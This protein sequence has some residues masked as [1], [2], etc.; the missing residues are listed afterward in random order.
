MYF[1]EREYVCPKCGAKKMFYVY[2]RTDASE[3]F[4]VFSSAY[5]PAK[6]WSEVDDKVIV[7][8]YCDKCWSTDTQ[9]YDFE[10]LRPPMICSLMI[11]SASSG[12]T[13]V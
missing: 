2:G 4:A 6:S 5:K 13:W 7:T 1:F 9:I 12:V 3:K 10:G 11:S 8:M